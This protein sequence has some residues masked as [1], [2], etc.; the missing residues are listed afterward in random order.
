MLFSFTACKKERETV[1]PQQPEVNTELVNKIK[2]WLEEQKSSQYKEEKKTTIQ[3]LEDNLQMDRLWVEEYKQNEKFI[4][5]PISKRFISANNKGKDPVSYL[6][7]VLDVAG[8]IRKGNIA[9]YMPVNKNANAN[10]EKNT[11][12]KIYNY[13]Q[14]SFD[15]TITY[16]S[17]TDELNYE[18]VFKNGNTRSLSVIKQKDEDSTGGKGTAVQRCWDVYWVTYYEDGSSTWDFMYTYCDDDCNTTRNVVGRGIVIACAGGS[19]DPEY[20]LIHNKLMRWEVYRETAGPPDFY[21]AVQAKVFLFG[22]KDPAYPQGGYFTST[23]EAEIWTENFGY[24]MDFQSLANQAWVGG[25]HAYHM[26]QGNVIYPPN[27]KEP[28]YVY[29]TQTWDFADVF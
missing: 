28:H 16:L 14:L 5:V 27:T 18:M 19:G 3:L 1:K 2:A 24:D 4:L 29:K 22:K 23:R 26:V 9:Q 7:L 17:V 13:Q 21:I 8:N 25:Q 15:A 20:E 10:L 11:L 12:Y 6:L